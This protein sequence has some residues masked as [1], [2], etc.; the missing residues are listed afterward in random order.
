[1]RSLAGF[2]RYSCFRPGKPL[3]FETPCLTAEL[4]ALLVCPETHQDVVLATTAE[5]ALLNEAIRSGQVQTVDGKPVDQPVDGAL[6]RVDRAIAYP[7]RDGIPVMLV[8]EGLVIRQ[9]N[10]SVEKG[11]I[12]SMADLAGKKLGVLLT[13]APAHPNFRPGAR[14]DECGARCGRPGLSLL[15]G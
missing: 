13:T 8:P 14:A 15:R 9:V 3:T 4:L 1:M 11:S 7:I 2:A 6:I 12:L 10:L 5:I